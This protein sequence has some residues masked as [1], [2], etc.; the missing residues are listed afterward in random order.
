MTMN[1]FLRA[2]TASAVAVAT[3][4][5]TLAFGQDGKPAAVP[6]PPPAEGKLVEKAAAPARRVEAAKVRIP[7]PAPAPAVQVNGAIMKMVVPAQ[8]VGGAEVDPMIAQ[9]LPGM[10]QPLARTELHLLLTVT[11]ASADQ[12]KA[13][14]ADRDKAAVAAARR[15]AEWQQGRSKL[16]GQ[17]AAPGGSSRRPSWT[18]PAP[19][20]R[21]TRRP[22]TS[23]RPNAGPGTSRNSRSIT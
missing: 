3:S 5:L 10:F 9:F 15:Y 7:F 17:Q 11:G 16:K 19:T 22:S 20:S 13:I 1:R 2:L 4:A 6:P 8:I 21:P 18:P 23:P 14:A 12:R